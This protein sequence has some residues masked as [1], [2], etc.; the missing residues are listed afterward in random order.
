MPA[1][2]A[3]QHPPIARGVRDSC[4]ASGTGRTMLYA[5]MARGELEFLKIGKRRLIED[6]ALRRW[7]ARHRVGGG[8]R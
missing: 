3:P 8:A 5:A 1:Q 6:E 4:R 7:L 2:P